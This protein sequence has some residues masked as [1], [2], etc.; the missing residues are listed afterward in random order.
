MICWDKELSPR[1]APVGLPVGGEVVF[2]STSTSQPAKVRAC[3]L[4]IPAM[5]PPIITAP[6]FDKFTP[7]SFVIYR[8]VTEAYRT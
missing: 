5:L 8:K 3:A 6:P 7:P 2:S 1:P 4:D